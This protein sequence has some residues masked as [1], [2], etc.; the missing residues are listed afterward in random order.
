M[1]LLISFFIGSFLLTLNALGQRPTHVPGS[2]EPANFFESPGSVLIY[3]IIPIIIGV[4]YFV[5]R[6]KNKKSKNNGNH[7]N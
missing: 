4:F 7:Q 1:R 2:G 6:K 3:I 5:W